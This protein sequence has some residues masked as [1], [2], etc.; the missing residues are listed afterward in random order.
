MQI[1]HQDIQPGNVTE[2]TSEGNSHNA[3]KN[4]GSSKKN[5]FLLLPTGTTF[6]Y[7]WIPQPFPVVVSVAT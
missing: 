5:Q 1:D 6:T 3:V 2:D 4:T 7:A